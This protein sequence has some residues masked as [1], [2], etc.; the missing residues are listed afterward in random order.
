VVFL[1]LEDGTGPS[2]CTFFEDVQGPYADVVF[3]S[4]LLLVRGITRRT[5][6]RGISMRATGAWELVGLWEAWQPDG[7]DAVHGR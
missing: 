2:D 5:G 1:T 4:W 7:I 6:A 3:H